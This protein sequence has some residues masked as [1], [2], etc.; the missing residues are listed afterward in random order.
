MI[1]YL[2]V[3]GKAIHDLLIVICKLRLR[4]H[5]ACNTEAYVTIVAMSYREVAAEEYYYIIYD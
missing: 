1:Q 3:T 5:R 4:L 2:G